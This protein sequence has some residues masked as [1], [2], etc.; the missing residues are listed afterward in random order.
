MTKNVSLERENFRRTSRFT[1]K[2][3]FR[4]EEEEMKWPKKRWGEWYEDF[5]ENSVRIVKR[6]VA[7][8]VETTKETASK[9]EKERK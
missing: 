6:K 1:K 3:G 5:V 8:C 9:E 4:K 7:P 2:R